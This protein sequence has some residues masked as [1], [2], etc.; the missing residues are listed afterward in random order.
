MAGAGRQ[1][2]LKKLNGLVNVHTNGTELFA[3][4]RVNTGYYWTKYLEPTEARGST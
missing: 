2:F 4:R 1:L 3:A